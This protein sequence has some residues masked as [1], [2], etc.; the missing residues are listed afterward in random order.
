[1]WSTS[2]RWSACYRS[3]RRRCPLCV[4]RNGR[5]CRTS[6]A[7]RC[8]SSGWP[9]Q[10]G[11]LTTPAATAPKAPPAR[12]LRRARRQWASRPLVP[13]P[14]LRAHPFPQPRPPRLRCRCLSRPA[15][16][17][18]YQSRVGRIRCRRRHSTLE[19][20]SEDRARPGTPHD[21]A[22]RASWKTLGIWDTQPKKTFRLNG[23]EGASEPGARAAQ[24]S[25]HKTAP[26]EISRSR[27]SSSP[28]RRSYTSGPGQQDWAEGLKGERAT[29][30]GDST[31]SRR[32]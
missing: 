14:S 10:F 17:P 13:P 20:A 31:A 7:M 23:H 9:I 5:R 32:A 19:S 29:R 2:R 25:S 21:E 16:S 24:S 4:R 8:R 28:R 1:M 15:G 3:A 6:A 18:P 30:A 12:R 11:L 22:L 26:G 27:T